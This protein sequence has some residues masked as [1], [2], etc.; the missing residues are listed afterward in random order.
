MAKS[1][2]TPNLT[3][4]GKEPKPR[5]YTPSLKTNEKSTAQNEGLVYVTLLAQQNERDHRKKMRVIEVGTLLTIVNKY[6]CKV[7]GLSINQSINQSNFD[8]GLSP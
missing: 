6:N 8:P 5:S 1:K 2:S 4:S 3:V 7:H